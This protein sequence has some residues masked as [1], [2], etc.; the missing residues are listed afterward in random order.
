MGWSPFCHTIY[1]QT[2]H[3]IPVHVF[4]ALNNAKKMTSCVNAE[5]FYANIEKEYLLVH[6]VNLS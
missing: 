4:T 6:Y 3:F 1:K 2:A 5:Q